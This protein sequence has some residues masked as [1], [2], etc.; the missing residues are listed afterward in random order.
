M[1]STSTRGSS[2]AIRARRSEITSSV[3][4]L[5][6]S[7]EFHGDVAASWLRSLPP[8]PNCSPVRRDAPS[9]LGDLADHLL[10]VTNDS[11]RLLERCACGSQVVEDESA[12]VDLRHQVGSER[13]VTEERGDDQNCR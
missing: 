2:L 12:L 10:E 3:E 5:C 1:N 11:V 8:R 4:R 6:V 9:H 13:L 7:F